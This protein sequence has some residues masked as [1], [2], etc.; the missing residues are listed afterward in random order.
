MATP[1]LAPGRWAHDVRIGLERLL[2]QD[3]TGRTIAAFDFDDTCLDGDISHAVLDELERETPGLVHAYQQAC[4]RDLREGW[5]GLVGTLVAGRSDADVAALT[6]RAMQRGLREGKLRVVPEMQELVAALHEAGWE[7]WV[8]TASAAPV[9][10][11]VSHHYGIEPHRIIGMSPVMGPDG[12]YTAEVL[13]PVTYREGKLEALRTCAHC[14]PT[15]AAGD[16]PSDLA[17]LRAARHGLLVDRGNTAL[18]E[19]A[20]TRGWWVQEGWR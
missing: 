8:V 19:E 6:T 9:V 14:D 7:V 11:C 5:V 4:A 13:E 2:A 17:L 20:R 16:S 3:L 15:L 12:R 18:R 10:R 1:R